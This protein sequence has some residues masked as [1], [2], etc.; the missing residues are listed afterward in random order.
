LCT[1][2]TQAL[3]PEDAADANDPGRGNPVPF[4][5]A[6]PRPR[7]QFPKVGV[8]TRCSG[9]LDCVEPDGEM[10]R[11]LRLAIPSIA[12]GVAD[13][14]LRLVL[15]GI[16]SYYINTASMVAFVLVTNFLRL[17]IEAV[18]GA[19]TDTEVINI[20]NALAS[21]GDDAYYRS[22]QIIKLSLIVQ[23]L[24]GVPILVGWV[25]GIS[26][27]VNWLLSGVAPEAAQ[28]AAE[29][30]QV[31]VFDY[32]FRVAGK[33]FLVPFH[34]N[35]RAPFEN[36]IDV[37][38][39]VLTMIAIGVVVGSELNVGDRPTLVSVAWIQVIAS[40]VKVTVKVSYVCFKGWFQPYREGF[41]GR[42]ALSV[43]FSLY[44][45]FDLYLGIS[46]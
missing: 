32:Y 34:M 4:F 3:R 18:S 37:V 6:P 8:W 11:I 41:F 46:L 19:I 40:F 31:I 39:A 9:F 27:L 21:G 38:G 43:S 15:I 12:G 28:L 42:F 29:Y 36:I 33:T 7:P 35:G 45:C 30:T 10:R 25:F 14:F 13:R 2:I 20:Q 24:I 44:A 23:T 26:G 16:I 17:T 1:V 5:D 22:G